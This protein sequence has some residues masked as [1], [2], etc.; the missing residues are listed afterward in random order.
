M[1]LKISVVSAI[2]QWLAHKRYLICH[3]LTSLKQKWVQQDGS[4]T[5]GS[6]AFFFVVHTVMA[7]H[8]KQWHPGLEEIQ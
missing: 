5:A 3:I 4:Y 6:N 7:S 8:Y 1:H 2:E